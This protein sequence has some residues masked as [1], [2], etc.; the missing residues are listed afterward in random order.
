[1]ETRH[2]YSVSEF[3][4]RLKSLITSNFTRISVEGEVSSVSV[5]GRGHV[6]FSLQ[7]K[8]AL[9]SC[10]VWQSKAPAYRQYIRQGNK[11]IVNGHLDLYEKGGRYSLIADSIEPSGLGELLL[12]LQKLRLKL[13]QEGL[14]DEARKRPLP[15]FPRKI[16]VVTALHGA[17]VRDIV[18]TITRRMP[19]HIVIAPARVQ[20]DGAAAE[21]IRGM[22]RLAQIPGIDVI[23]IGRGG[24]SF[25]DLFQF[26]DE[27]LVRAVV[28]SPVPVISA[29]GHERDEA[30]TD[31]AADVR[32]GTPTAAGQRVVPDRGEVMAGLDA[33]QQ[34]LVMGLTHRLDTA[35]MTFDAAF[36]ALLQ[37]ARLRIDRAD[38]R[39]QAANLALMR[40]NPV[41]KLKGWDRS[42]RDTEQRLMRAGSSML[43]TKDAVLGQLLAEFRSKDPYG[44]LKRGYAMLKLQDGTLV[45][46]PGD[47]SV[48]QRITGILKNGRLCLG[49]EARKACERDRTGDG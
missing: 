47:V 20:G 11:I 12:K 14:F 37:S 28:A 18:R 1:M 26:N 49:V 35:E 9:L 8:S 46:T 32:A 4:T 45:R 31:L 27:A 36:K 44:P 19:S 42:L 48:G 13:Q 43:K 24:G 10:I 2:I 29:V 16:G 23:I 40:H 30:L 3:T 6:Y 39:M 41:E 5:S 34:R 25:E 22:Q 38:R 33:W 7:D 17:A 15:G 21:V